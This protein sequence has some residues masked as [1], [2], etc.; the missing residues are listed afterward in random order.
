[1]KILKKDYKRGF[2]ELIPENVGDLYA[3]YRIL[4]SGDKVRATTSRRI[5]RKDDN[6]PFFIE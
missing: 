2:V 6:F 1:M 3:I 5:R 4:K